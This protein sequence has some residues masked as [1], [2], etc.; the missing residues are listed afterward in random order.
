MRQ[1][2][3][4]LAL[5]MGAVAAFQC[6]SFNTTITL[7]FDTA[8]SRRSATHTDLTPSH[9]DMARRAR[10]PIHLPLL[11]AL[12]RCR[13][14]LRRNAQIPLQRQRSPDRRRGPLQRGQ[15]LQT[16]LSMPSPYLPSYC[17][18]PI[19]D[20]RLIVSFPAID[21]IRRRR[22]HLLRQR[23]PRYPRAS[24]AAVPRREAV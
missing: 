7:R 14:S 19:D 17:P 2:T 9:Q 8:P 10:Q 4:A 6:S 23:L 3:S 16:S 20:V 12:R 1:S 21:D 11:P 13:A 22:P 18:S 15:L 24:R 5:F